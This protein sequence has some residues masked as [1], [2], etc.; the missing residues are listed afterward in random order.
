MK[1]DDIMLIENENAKRLKW[2]LAQVKDVILGKR[3]K[4]RIVRLTTSSGVN[5]TCPKNLPIRIDV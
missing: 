3:N 5:K 1:R 4:V 2:L